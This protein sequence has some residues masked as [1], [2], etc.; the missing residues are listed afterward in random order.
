[1]SQLINEL[2]VHCKTKRKRKSGYNYNYNINFSFYCLF[3]VFFSSYDINM[4]SRLL[5]AQNIFMFFSIVTLSEGKL[6][7]R[8]RRVE[9]CSYGVVFGI[10]YGNIV[11]FQVSL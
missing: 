9:R 10:F 2:L 11:K 5:R 7:K 1:M 6:M 8:V 3:V 4:L